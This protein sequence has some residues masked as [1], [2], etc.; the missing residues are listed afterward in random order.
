[1]RIPALATVLAVALLP[2]ARPRTAFAE[3]KPIEPGPW[4]FGA[5]AGLNFAQS[6]Y[7]DNWAG[8]DRG[9]IVWVANLEGKA[10][11]QFNPTYNHSNVLQLAYGQTSKQVADPDDARKSRW[12]SPEKSTDLI[13]FESVARFSLNRYVD[14]YFSFR[15]DSQFLD[16][17]DPAGTIRMNPVRLTETA[18]LARV[19]HK[20]EKEEF[21]S[22][23]GFG[24]RQTF[25]RRFAEAEDG[26]RKKESF[27]TRDGGFE[28]QT[29]VTEPMLDEKVVYKGK[30]LVFYP[31][32]FSRSDALEEFDRIAL[33]QDPTR[34]EVQ[35]FWR[36]PDVNFQNSFTAQITKLLSVNLYLQWVYN[37]LDEATDVDT[38]LDPAVL[39]EKVDAGIRKGGQFK[40]TLSL[41]LSYTLL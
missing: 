26:S 39:M 12:D 6:A 24:F 31:V 18:G 37:K 1:M 33:A 34:E 40:Q 22:R 35:D 20:T 21:I 10:E 13:Q 11:R 30:L 23:V 36:S 27:S 16:Q 3:G 9:S 41:G 2:D 32:Y 29:T 17:S 38:S 14:P 7:S 4:K 5:I 28:F 8:G 15:L 25:A 19:F